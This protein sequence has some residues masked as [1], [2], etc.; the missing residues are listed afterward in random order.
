MFGV[1]KDTS[2]PRELS[3]SVRLHK[4][5]FY[6]TENDFFCRTGNKDM[7]RHWDVWPP[8]RVHSCPFARPLVLVFIDLLYIAENK[9]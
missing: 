5:Y 2:V 8:I 1:I 9:T 7:D 6:L 4:I 3:N